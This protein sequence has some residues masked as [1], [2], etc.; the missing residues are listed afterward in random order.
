MTA[1]VLGI[2][3]LLYG[4]WMSIRTPWIRPVSG[5]DLTPRR[6][7]FNQADVVPGT[8]FYAL[9][10]AISFTE[11]E[12]ISSALTKLRET[13]WPTQI[14]PEPVPSAKPREISLDDPDLAW[15]DPEPLDMFTDIT[16]KTDEWEGPDWHQNQIDRLEQELAA[17]KEFLDLGREAVRLPCPQVPTAT[18]NGFLLPYLS[19]VRSLARAYCISA[20]KKAHVGDF[21][22]AFA[23]L[24]TAMRIGGLVSKGGCLIN[25]LVDIACSQ[26]ACET[27]WH[28][29]T[30]YSVP[31]SSEHRFLQAVQQFESE[32]E[33]LAEALRYEHLTTQGSI[34]LLITKGPGAF[35][36]SGGLPHQFFM[37]IAG[38]IAGVFLG[39]G[40]AT[41][42][43]N[44]SYA[45]ARLI[46]IAEN[47]YDPSASAAFEASLRSG[48]PA[49]LLLRRDPVGLILAGMFLPSLSHAITKAH[50]RTAMLRTLTAYLAIR[51]FLHQNGRFPDVPADLV[52][53]ELP[54]WPVDPFD[55]NPIRCRPPVDGVWLV[56][57]VGENLKDDGGEAKSWFS[58]SMYT[59]N[60]PGYRYRN[61]DL[62]IPSRPF[63]RDSQ[64]NDKSDRK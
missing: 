38:G 15:P 42:K 11:P 36:A 62:V 4:I 29:T 50:Q 61:P 2:L 57:S 26:I 35:G 45:Y 19:P 18:D 39:S 47:P 48:H 22:G 10:E 6:P 59:R 12:T 16:D 55:G 5:I 46:Q 7:V 32:I 21:D 40:P 33:P 41:V 24:D 9:Q 23:D 52:P 14:I 25:Y 63:T 44:L 37:P 28:I 56:Y 34:D 30:R 20:Y 53:V 58:P 31:D 51:E 64:D 8:P 49:T 1:V 13:G 27:A 3:L 60:R 54:R 43:R 17:L